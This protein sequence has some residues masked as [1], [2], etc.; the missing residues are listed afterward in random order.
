VIRQIAVESFVFAVCR[1]DTPQLL[2][3]ETLNRRISCHFDYIGWAERFARAKM[4][5]VGVLQSRQ[6][7]PFG[8]IET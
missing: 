2:P 7:L 8:S 5:L 1:P 6:A 3:Q 4:V